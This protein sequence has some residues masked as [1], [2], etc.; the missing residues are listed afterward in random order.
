MKL[1]TAE[2]I[3]NLDQFTIQQEPISSIDLM[4]RASWACVNWI[5]QN[6]P[7]EHFIIFC[8]RGNNGGDGLAI[9]RLLHQKGKEVKVFVLEIGTHTPDFE[10]NLQR[11]PRAIEQFF[12]NENTL[13]QAVIHPNSVIIDAIFGVGLSKPLVDWVVEIV[14]FINF[15]KTTV[16]AIDMP[17][18]MFANLP[19]PKDSTLIQASHTLTFHRPKLN[20]LLPQTGNFVGNLVILDIGLLESFENELV[21]QY[22]LNTFS[23][24]AFL[25][26]R[27][28]PRPVFSHKGSY[29]HS[30]LAV[31]SYGK[32]GAATLAAQ[33]CLRAGIGLLTIFSAGSNHVILQTS[34]P[35]AMFIASETA[36]YISGKT[37]YSR[38]N[39]IGVGAGIGTAQETQEFLKFLIQESPVPLVLDADALNILSENPT[40][41]A[42]LPPKS[43]LTPHPKE[44][45]RLVGK[46]ENDHECL[47]KLQTFAKKNHVYVVLKGAYSKIATPDGNILFNTS[48]NAGMATGGSGDVLTGI[49]AGLLA[50]HYSPLEAACIGVYVHG[51]AADLAVKKLGMPSLIASDLIQYISKAFLELQTNS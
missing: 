20:M 22:Y 12:L 31:G 17:T 10:E 1:L 8:G 16:I 43:I 15:A 23:E 30:L 28:Q 51:L 9:A 47:E 13:N 50:Q 19:Q 32:A 3:K 49:I 27:L 39:A 21:N 18:G 38:Y 42:F 46:W 29:G 5:L 44:F 34:A 25:Y 36:Q 14:K 48:G 6:L 11:L 2:Q 26:S 35:E 37:D 41:L 40:W 24:I 45:E 4:E 7:Q 33:A